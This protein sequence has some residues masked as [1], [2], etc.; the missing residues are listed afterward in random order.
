VA[1]TGAAA[2]ASEAHSERVSKW[3]CWE[4]SIEFKD[5]QKVSQAQR[6]S[7]SAV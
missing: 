6:A 7:G 5:S 3:C 2:A 1:A 4:D